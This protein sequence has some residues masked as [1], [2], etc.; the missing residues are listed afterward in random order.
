MPPITPTLALPVAGDAAGTAV[1]GG[2]MACT[3][4][5]AP[6]RAFSGAGVALMGRPIS[7]AFAPSFGDPSDLGN[8]RAREFQPAEGLVLTVLRAGSTGSCERGRSPVSVSRPDVRMSSDKPRTTGA[9]RL[10]V[11]RGEVKPREL[12]DGVALPLEAPLFQPEPPLVRPPV[13]G[14]ELPRVGCVTAGGLLLG[15]EIVVGGVL[16]GRTTGAGAV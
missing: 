14:C 10:L 15:R 16:L 5:T 3:G 12:L 9:G 4:R 6:P 8:V 7:I 2:T 11:A 13:S 1:S